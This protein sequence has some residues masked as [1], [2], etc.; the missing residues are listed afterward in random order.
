MRA[1]FWVGTGV[2]GVVR[3]PSQVLPFQRSRHEPG[4]LRSLPSDYVS[5]VFEDSHGLVWVGTSGEATRIDKQTGQ[6]TRF[7][8]ASAK[9]MRILLRLLKTARA[10][11]GSVRGAKG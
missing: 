9:P 7:K 6:Y 4:N 1:A 8:L 5:S 3:M 2:G 11:Y 10:S